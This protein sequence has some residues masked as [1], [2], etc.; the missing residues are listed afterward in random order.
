MN[1]TKFSINEHQIVTTQIISSFTVSVSNV[2]LFESANLQVRLFDN[3][4]NI[5]NVFPLTL[6]GT[7]YTNWGG[8]DTYLY[9]YVADKMGYTLSSV[10]DVSVPDIPVPVP[11]PVPVPD[12]PVPV[13]DIPVPDVSDVPEVEAPVSDVPVTD[14][15]V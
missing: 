9:Q 14:A 12:I 10:P 13:P 15:S 4:N 2:F 3:N 5:A 8:D 11:V 7:D 1:N 6:T